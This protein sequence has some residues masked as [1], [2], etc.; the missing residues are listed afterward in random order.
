MAPP[1]DSDATISMTASSP[2]THF[3]K[4]TCQSEIYSSPSATETL[5]ATS[6][7]ST[8][9]STPTEVSSSLPSPSSGSTEPQQPR[10][11]RRKSLAP[12][13]SLSLGRDSKCD[14]PGLVFRVPFGAETVDVI[15]HPSDFTK[16][17]RVAELPERRRR[18]T[19]TG[20][21][22]RYD[23]EL[24]DETRVPLIPSTV[25][26][27]R[28]TE[29]VLRHEAASKDG[30]QLPPPSESE[31]FLSSLVIP[32]ILQAEA[33]LNQLHSSEQQS[34]L[35]ETSKPHPRRVAATRPVNYKEDVDADDETEDEYNSA[36]DGENDMEPAQ[37][38][39]IA[40]KKKKRRGSVSGKKKRVREGEKVC[41]SCRTTVTPIWREVKENWGE[42]WE[43]VM[44]CNAC[45]LRMILFVLH[46]D[47]V[48][49]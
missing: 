36:F 3:A 7:L 39:P 19:I 4:K 44:L 27:R 20:P 15:Q 38:V 24:V 33:H 13:R 26:R 37:V 2:D 17:V 5:V 34:Q 29:V 31:L 28:L 48:C 1:S 8:R 35:F 45:G 47:I 10:R 22:V 25:R 6:A 32:Y 16:D 49:S 43:D 14:A 12:R 23:E 42:G 9:S 46:L 41:M 30:S 21:M 18:S 40:N 11:T